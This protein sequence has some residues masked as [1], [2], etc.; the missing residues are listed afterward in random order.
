MTL[1]TRSSCA[2]TAALL[3][4]HSRSGWAKSNYSP[5]L[6]FCFISVAHIQPPSPVHMSCAARLNK[7]DKCT[8]VASLTSIFPLCE[9]SPAC[10]LNFSAFRSFFY[11]KLWR[12]SRYPFC[13]KENHQS[14]HGGA[15]SHSIFSQSTQTAGKKIGFVRR[16]QLIWT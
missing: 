1:G 4:T 3:S 12:D 5:C 13:L 10:Q 2:N 6:E 14:Q 7:A 9:H 11:P 16:V 8:T 15:A